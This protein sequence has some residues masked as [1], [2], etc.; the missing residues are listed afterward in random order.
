M[1]DYMFDDNDDAY[2]TH[3]LDFEVLSRGGEPHIDNK[4]LRD[5]ELLH[6]DNE[7]SRD[8]ELLHIDN[9]SSRDEEPSQNKELLKKKKT[10]KQ[11]R[12]N[13]NIYAHDSSTGNMFGHLWSKH[14]IDKEHP[15]GT[16]TGSLI[17]KAMHVITKCYKE[18]L[19]RDLV[20]FIIEDCQPLN[21]L[22]TL[23]NSEWQLLDELIY[24]L[25]PFYEA[26]TIFSGSIYPILNLIYHIMMLL[27]KKFAPSDGQ[28][29]DDYANLLFRFREQIN[30][31]SQLITDNKNSDESDANYN[32]MLVISEK[33]RQP[34]HASRRQKKKNYKKV[35]K[36]QYNDP[37]FKGHYSIEPL[38]VTEKLSDLVKAVCYLSLQEYWDVLKETGLIALFLDPRIKNLKFI[39]DENIKLI[40]ISMVRRLCIE[41]EHRRP[42]VK[43]I[44]KIYGFAKSSSISISNSTMVND[45]ISDLYDN[46]KSNSA[47]KKTEVDRYLNE[48]KY[49]LI[50][51]ISVPSECLFSDAGQHITALHNR[52]QPDMVEQMLL[53]KRNMEHFSIFSLD[54]L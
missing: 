53:L 40:T 9:E 50:P 38:V 41:E 42:L 20:E 25:K 7:S 35:Q 5:E 47:Y 16:N 13:Q 4:S 44:L 48:L 28:T 54:E 15:D 29:D 23:T 32:K 30:D 10:N 51:A 31:Q 43:E 24:L 12:S 49:L 8:K 26:T 39:D 2:D 17:I 36:K 22:L 1:S 18:K 45:L 46:K 21:I 52:L 34:L 37:W 27:I 14:R 3:S 11:K 6:I 33:L 19:T